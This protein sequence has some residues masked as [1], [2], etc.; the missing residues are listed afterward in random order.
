MRLQKF[1]LIFCIIIFIINLILFLKINTLDLNFLLLFSLLNILNILIIFQK[2]NIIT[3]YSIFLASTIFSI[4]IFEIYS[5]DLFKYLSSKNSVLELKIEN[6]DKNLKKNY[7]LAPASPTNYKFIKKDRIIPLSG[8]RNVLNY[9]CKEGEGKVFY[10][11]DEYGFNNLY[12]KHSQEIYGVLLGDSFAHG[13]CVPNENSLNSQLEKKFGKKFLNLGMRG[14][15]QL[16][17][18]AIFKEYGESIKPKIVVLLIFIDNDIEDFI[19]ELNFNDTYSKYLNEQ[20]FSQ[21]LKNQSDE[22]EKIF[23]QNFKQEYSEFEK[24]KQNLDKKKK[25]NINP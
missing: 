5:S 21:N 8:L 24:N 20:N 25:N 7:Y 19:N 3:Y 23:Y 2:K 18:Y 16:T 22:V 9:L 11:S 15:G 1:F 12:G 4:F 14:S 10:Q 6:Y 17:Q 13:E